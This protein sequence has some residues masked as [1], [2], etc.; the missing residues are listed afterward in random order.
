M[1]VPLGAFVLDPTVWEGADEAVRISALDF[2]TMWSA[3]NGTFVV[4]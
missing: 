2:V 3:G 4:M 1:L